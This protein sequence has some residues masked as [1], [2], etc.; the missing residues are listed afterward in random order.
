M[1]GERKLGKLGGLWAQ[2]VEVDWE[3]LYGERRPRRISLPTYPFARE[4][5]W[6][7]EPEE[8]NLNSGAD[9]RGLTAFPPDPLAGLTYTSKWILAP[10]ESPLLRQ[11]PDGK[12]LIIYRAEGYGFE[13][14]LVCPGQ[15][16]SL[17]LGT[18]NIQNHDHRWTIDARDFDAFAAALR[19]IGEI[20]EV[21]FLGGLNDSL[22]N[23]NTLEN[24]GPD[25]VLQEV[26]Y[27]S[28][29]SSALSK[30]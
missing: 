17:C 14:A 7:P 16:V 29:L 27:S 19:D 2:G 20:Q 23:T 30:R 21:Y 1:G 3:V 26:E 11:P 4:R 9:Q 6:V 22:R 5:Y 25:A 18:Q 12:R 13:S 10:P 28:W 15:T 24:S 8:A